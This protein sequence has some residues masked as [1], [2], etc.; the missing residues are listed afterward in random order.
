[1]AKTRY[2]HLIKNFTF[3]DYGQGD[4]RQGTKMAGSFFGYDVC[5]EYGTYYAAGKMSKS[6]KDAVAHDYDQVMIWMGTDTYDLGY[7]GAEVELCLGEEKEKHM[8]TTA[9]AVAVPKGMPYIPAD[10]TRMDERFIS[11][12]VAMTAKTKS[13]AVTLD[14]RQPEPAGF[15]RSKYV[16]NVQHLAFT[17]NGPWHYGPLNPDTHDGA[18]TDIHGKDFEFHMSY[19]SMNRAPYRFGPVPDKPHVHPYTE[20]LLFMG[21]DTED[22]NDLGAEIEVYMGK[23]MEKHVVTKPCV[24]IQPRH[25]AHCPVIVTRQDRPW[26]FAVVRP[27]GHVGRGKDGYIT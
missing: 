17:R 26:I 20:F 27:W 7:L 25:H 22:L 3:K 23:E 21:A 24:A 19:E 4:Y 10:V 12:T 11:M 5:M 2:G 1:M 16:Q 6:Y 8:I 15:M 18:I 14:D 9:T 13:K